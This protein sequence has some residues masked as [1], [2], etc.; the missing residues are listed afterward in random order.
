[1][2]ALP[3]WAQQVGER[4]LTNEA[5]GQPDRPDIVESYDDPRMDSLSSDMRELGDALGRHG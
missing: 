4:R 1:M 2:A 5:A 3:I